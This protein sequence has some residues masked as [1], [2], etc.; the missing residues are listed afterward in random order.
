MPRASQTVLVVDDDE[1]T[2]ALYEGWLGEVHEVHAVERG[3]EALDNLDG[4]DIVLLDRQLPGLSGETV[5]AEI[6]RREDPPPVA[7]VTG[8]TP[9][10]DILGI[11][12]DDYLTKPVTQE[13]LFATVDRLSR[14]AEYDDHFAE[15]AA[16][17]TKR[18]RLEAT[19]EDFEDDSEY[20]ALCERVDSLRSTVDCYLD[21]FDADDFEAA[22][23]SPEF[24]ATAQGVRLGSVE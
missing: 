22:F 4:V 21:E 19:G 24:D 20:R 8:V 18:A 2:R 6:R 3:K 1:S 23:R 10:T 13:D 17:A 14:R 5:A 16:L 9:D 7:M 11:A 12:C 15:F